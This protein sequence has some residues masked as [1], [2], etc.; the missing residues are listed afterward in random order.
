[1]ISQSKLDWVNL[2]TATMHDVVFRD[3]TINELDLAGATQSR[4]GFEETRAAQ[5]DATRAPPAP[6]RPWAWPAAW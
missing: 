3:R 6:R 4:V 2:R 1:M 5:S